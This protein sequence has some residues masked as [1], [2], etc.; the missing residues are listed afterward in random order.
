MR[1]YYRTK[2]AP[3][4]SG[5]RLA[6]RISMALLLCA[7]ALGALLSCKLPMGQDA[8]GLTVVIGASAAKTLV[9]NVD[10]NAASYSISGSGPNGATFSTTL[11]SGTS[12]TI[13]VQASGTWTVSASGKNAAGTF[14]T[15]GSAT[16]QVSTGSTSTVTITVTPIVGPGSLSLTLTWPAAS[17]ANPSIQAQLV[18]ATGSPTT[19]AFSTPSNGSASYSGSSIMNGYYTLTLQLFDGTTLVMG[20]VDVVEIIQGQ[21]TSGTYAFSAVNGVDGKIT[22]NITPNLLNPLA[23]TMSGQPSSPI[24]SGSPVTLS[25]S[26]PAG[27]GN[28]TYA[29]YVNGV[30][31][32]V[33]NT[34]TLN[35]AT[36][37][38]AV[39]T[40]R[41]D[42]TAFSANGLQAGSTTA[43][44]TVA[45]L[46]HATL[47][48]NANTETNLAGY[49]LYMGTASGVYG[50]PTTLGLVTTTTVTT[51]VSGATYYFAL[52]AFN[53]AGQESSK[54]SEISY[55][56]P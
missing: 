13:P 21:T 49:K 35:S 16:T 8:T 25:A 52:T 34:F 10:M 15:Y 39:G 56:A 33:G 20:A 11:S 53:T 17:V 54:S 46:D 26:V 41:V 30:S 48:W 32:A 9:P 29:W 37:S 14:I 12:T 42:V 24:G 40:Y 1:D 27:T 5:F 45:Q 2:T 23:V 44:L 31:Q 7:A 18:P 47:L 38:L 22:V 6:A 55:K 4:V 19:L 43:T 50:T 28:A 3:R 36:A 51:L